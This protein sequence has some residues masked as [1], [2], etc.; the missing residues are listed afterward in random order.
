M[1]QDFNTAE[2]TKIFTRGR[3]TLPAQNSNSFWQNPK[4]IPQHSPCI[5]RLSLPLENEHP[6]ALL[7]SWMVRSSGGLC[8]DIGVLLQ[9]L[10]LWPEFPLLAFEESLII[11]PTLTISTRFFP[12]PQWFLVGALEA[13]LCC[14]CARDGESLQCATEAVPVHN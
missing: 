5:F 10:H 11:H 4:I 2:M 3:Q 12:S 8:A 14:C 1:L 13:I 9:L 7:C 6:L